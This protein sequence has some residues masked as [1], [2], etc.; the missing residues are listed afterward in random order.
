[1]L[2][3]GRLG[4]SLPRGNHG[5]LA[6]EQ[7]LETGGARPSGR[8][9]RV[10]AV[11]AA[12]EGQ[13]GQRSPGRSCICWLTGEAPARR[14]GGGGWQGE[15]T[16]NA[17]RSRHAAIRLCARQHQRACETRC[18]RERIGARARRQSCNG[19][20]FWLCA[21]RATQPTIRVVDQQYEHGAGVPC[22]WAR[23][24]GLAAHLALAPLAA[25]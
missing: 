6:L 24:C 18:R 3:V 9:G 20:C 8:L 16:A 14:F 15:Q 10:E 2:H 5:F 25:R 17:V 19:A 13:I 22:M 23:P 7:S 12:D 11:L 1:M 4:A 21:E